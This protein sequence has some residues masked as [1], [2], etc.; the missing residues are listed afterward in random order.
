[1]RGAFRHDGFL[2]RPLKRERWED[3]CDNSSEEENVNDRG[4]TR[5]PP[6]SR[7]VN[8]K[9]YDEA[10]HELA[11]GATLQ[12][13]NFLTLGE[14]SN[15]TQGAGSSTDLVTV[16]VE[17]PRAV[18]E[19]LSRGGAMFCS[20]GGQGVRLARSD[21]DAGLDRGGHDLAVGDLPGSGGTQSA[22][23]R[24]RARK[25]RLRPRAPAATELTRKRSRDE[26]APPAQASIPE[27]SEEV[28]AHRFKKRKICVENIKARSEF[29]YSEVVERRQQ[30]LQSSSAPALVPCPRTPDPNDRSVTKRGWEHA[31]I[32]WKDDLRSFIGVQPEP[33]QP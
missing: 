7:L 28:W 18:A 1:M 16:P 27:V 33:E 6:I 17:M 19:H 25:P 31:I 8:M 24:P 4:G 26:D 11:A 23:V 22:P 5:S 32:A 15:S 9:S 29:R 10:A 21:S 12:M 2:E 30:L 13:Q 3:L 20:G 14:A